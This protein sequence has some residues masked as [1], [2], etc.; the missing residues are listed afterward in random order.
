MHR[1]HQEIV[2][3]PWKDAK[4]SVGE[5]GKAHP[6]VALCPLNRLPIGSDLLFADTLTTSDDSKWFVQ[7]DIILVGL[8]DYQDEKADVILK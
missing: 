6:V 8:R 1:Q 4:E 7:G 5:H 2:S 3:H